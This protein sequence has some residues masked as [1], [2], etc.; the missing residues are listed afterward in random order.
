MPLLPRSP[1]A[2]QDAGSSSDLKSL[3]AG[4]G[5]EPVAPPKAVTLTALAASPFIDLASPVTAAEV[6]Q[7]RERKM[8]LCLGGGQR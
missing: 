5:G 6:V 7:V 4:A 1:A 2:P 8:V 3:D